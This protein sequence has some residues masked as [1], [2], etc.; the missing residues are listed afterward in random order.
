MRIGFFAEN[1]L[2]FHGR[3][4]EE[5]PLGGTETGIIR[6]AEALDG[7]G[8]DVTVFTSFPNPPETKP[9][10]LHAG[11]IHSA[12]PFDVLVIVKDPRPLAF[13]LPAKT[14]FFL[15]GDGPDQYA[16]YGL[17][18]KRISGKLTGLLTVSDWQG[19][20]LSSQ[21]GFPIDKCWYIG[22]GVHL[23]YFE[24][25]EIRAR[26]RLMFASAPYR[27]LDVAYNAFIDIQ[28]RHPDAHFDIFAGF[29]LYNTDKPF[30]GPLVAQ[31]Q[32][33]KELISKNPGCTLHGNIKQKELAREYMK[34]SV[35]LYPNTIFET[36]CIVALEAQA[37]GCPT[38]TS[39]NSGIAES[40]GDGGVVINGTPGSPGYME[41]L[42]YVLHSL[43]SDNTYWSNLSRS[44]LDKDHSWSSVARRFMASCS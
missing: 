44:A 39:N 8:H 17:G 29:D 33:L 5:R 34:S 38:V 42:H 21:S 11:Q 10:Y 24:G 31:F 19:Q 32:K 7:L 20:A 15:T 6:L 43:L 23:P 35:L 9:H 36:C 18:D 28:K 27:G 13:N 26:K 25:S 41:E 22:N 16:N 4:L 30:S 2:P 12:A 40:A 37:A 3:T 14:L 1:C